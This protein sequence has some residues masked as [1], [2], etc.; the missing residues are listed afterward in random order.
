MLASPRRPP[1]HAHPDA[2]V[3]AMKAAA[4][5]A[6]LPPTPQRVQGG[7][8]RLVALTTSNVSAGPGGSAARCSGRLA[9]RLRHACVLAALP[10]SL[11]P[12]PSVDALQVLAVPR[13]HHELV[14]LPLGAILS[15]SP[16]H[17]LPTYALDPASCSKCASGRGPRAHHYIC[18]LGTPGTNSLVAAAREK[19]HITTLSRA[20]QGWA[21]CPPGRCGAYINVYSPASG[22][23]GEWHCNFCLHLNTTAGTPLGS[24]R[25]SLD[26]ESSS[27]SSL[28][29]PSTSGGLPPSAYVTP[30]TAPT[31]GPALSREASATSGGGAAPAGPLQPL[32]QEEAVDYITPH[33]EG[34]GAAA[35][36]G[37]TGAWALPV[38]S[39]TSAGGV[40]VVV[41]DTVASF[42]DL[43]VV[44]GAL[45]QAATALP[46]SA[47]VALLA[48]SAAAV[49][50]Y[51]L[52]GPGTEAALAE[53]YGAASDVLPGN[54]RA[55][56]AELLRA[57]RPGVHVVPAGACRAALQAAILS[58]RWV[59][60]Q[61][62]AGYVCLVLPAAAGSCSSSVGIW[63]GLSLFH[64]PCSSDCQ[65]RDAC[66]P[67]RT[68]LPTISQRPLQATQCCRGR[69]TLHPCCG[70]GRAAPLP[71]SATGSARAAQRTAGATR[72]AATASWR[73]PVAADGPG[74][75]HPAAWPCGGGDHWACIAGGRGQGA[76]RALPLG[77]CI[78]P[79]P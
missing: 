70:G 68:K 4:A 32:L 73:A 38:G 46:D 62:E 45:L 60:L 50:A 13:Q 2:G 63:P 44:R 75:G 3:E 9:H 15:P 51:R 41:V 61:R 59:W 22:D 31:L 26:L 48:S 6:A 72:R 74:S 65:C 19:N 56:D 29:G 33:G 40:A 49:A 66:P 27:S 11:Q 71:A 76:E 16:S 21:A 34:G 47:R 69:A 28:L 57:L 67:Y 79:F 55:G 5:A 25:P 54:L 43:E 37:L 58:L 23:R 77:A 52:A 35:A 18:M 39:S 30:P 10:A 78:G 1:G 24:A 64:L 36:A 7:S 20:Y 42:H 14:G 8:D 17:A 53:G 12:C